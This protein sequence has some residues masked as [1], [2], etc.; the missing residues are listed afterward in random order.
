M[1]DDKKSGI[2]IYS[3]NKNLGYQKRFYSLTNSVQNGWLYGI[4]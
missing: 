2:V 4:Y 3:W 1:T